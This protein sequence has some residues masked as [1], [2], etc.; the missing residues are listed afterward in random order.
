MNDI[1]TM[2]LPSAAAGGAAAYGVMKTL[3][4]GWMDHVFQK[5]NDEFR[6]RLKL[7]ENQTIK[8]YEKKEKSDLVIKKYSRV[9]LQSA[10]DLQDRLW[11][12]SEKQAVSRS[13]ILLF[14]EDNKPSSSVWPMTQRHYLSSTLFLFSQYFFWIA[15]IKKDLQ[16]LE[17]SNNLETNRFNYLIKRIERSLA[18]S[19]LQKLTGKSNVR[20]SDQPIFQLMQIEIGEFLF[21]ENNEPKTFLKFS[22]MIKSDDGIPDSII[23]L[24]NLLIGSVSKQGFYLT[25]V[26]ITANALVDLIKFLNETNKLYQ[27]DCIEKI[28]ISNFNNDE[29]NRIWPAAP[30]QPE[31]LPKAVP[32]SLEN[33]KNST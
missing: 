16:Y 22:S 30:I 25:R 18:E 9:V 5:E 29:Y 10:I 27:A 24:K 14:S 26:K 21:E 4:K 31:S 32:R 33:K 8:E 17:F 13:P 3:G 23:A 15:R 28:K 1:I 11:H 7:L 2:L 20:L 12:L 19:S 6:H